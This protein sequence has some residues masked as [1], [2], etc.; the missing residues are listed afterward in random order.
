MFT[1]TPIL[2]DFET[3]LSKWTQPLFLGGASVFTLFSGQLGTSSGSGN[4]Y[5]NKPFGPDVEVYVTVPTIAL[6]PSGSMSIW[7]RI[8]SPNS[9]S[10]SGYSASI[11]VGTSVWKLNRLDN[12]TATQIATGALTPAA[13]DAFGISIIGTLLQF[14]YKVAAGTWTMLGSVEDSTYKAPGVVGMILPDATVRA[15]DFGGGTLSS[16][17]VQYPRLLI[18]GPL[19]PRSPALPFPQA[20]QGNVIFQQVLP[21]IVTASASINK[22]VNKNM[23]ATVTL[24][25]AFL[26]LVS[27]S[28]VATVTLT[29]SIIK[30]VQKFLSSTVTL[31]ATLLKP[32]IFARTLP[33][34]VNVV[35]SITK[36]ANKGMVATVTTQATISKVVNT[37]L[38]ATVTMSASVVKVVNKS[39]TATV[40]LVAALAKQF[41]KIVSMVATVTTS[42]SMSKVVNKTMSANVTLSATISKLVSKSLVATVTVVAVAKKIVNKP[43]V[44]NVSLVG[45][46]GAVKQIAATGVRKLRMM[47]GMGK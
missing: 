41:L 22:V 20:S 47:M 39:L 16:Y 13:G 17:V 26:K 44:A 10:I 11:N 25:A 38:A 35:G 1:N 33:A 14:W 29:A 8:I 12:N 42:A 9:A 37:L 31:V 15:D 28:I 45:T 24:V 27:K 43:L 36:T 18:L 5:I 46:L 19:E 21:A 30:S 34:T 4:G 40:T 7:C 32:A 3:D 2:D 23:V 6:S